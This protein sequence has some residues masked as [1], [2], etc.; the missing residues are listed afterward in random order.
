MNRK[1]KM[2]TCLWGREE[3]GWRSCVEGGLQW[4]SMKGIQGVVNADGG[5]H[6]LIFTNLLQ[7]TSPTMNE[8][9]KA[10]LA[11]PDLATTKLQVS[12][13]LRDS[14]SQYHLCS[15]MR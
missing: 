9:Y 15:A 1:L 2:V 14:Y 11:P 6:T 12:E 7:M 5:D 10:H 13:F 3:T 8:G 4:G